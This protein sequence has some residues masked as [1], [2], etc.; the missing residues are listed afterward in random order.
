MNILN[1]FQFISQIQME[2]C[3]L[4]GKNVKKVSKKCSLIIK[5]SLLLNNQVL[6]K[7]LQL[8]IFQNHQQKKM[9]KKL[10]FHQEILSETYMMK[11]RRLLKILQCP[12]QMIWK[13]K[14]SH[15]SLCLKE[16]LLLSYSTKIKFLYHTEFF[17]MIRITKKTLYFLE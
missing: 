8:Y 16:N 3:I 1:I 15:Q 5:Q 17:Q 7:L 11:L 2:K 13:C 10:F 14:N 6:N 4:N 9:F 12:Y